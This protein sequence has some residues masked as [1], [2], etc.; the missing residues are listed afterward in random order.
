MGAATGL[1]PPQSILLKRIKRVEERSRTGA[2]IEGDEV[3][4]SMVLARRGLIVLE[5]RIA[6]IT[7]AGRKA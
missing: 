4:T 3:R 2:F 1:T 6:H 5:G 7:E